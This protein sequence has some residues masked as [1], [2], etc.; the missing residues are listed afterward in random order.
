VG[1]GA[2]QVPETH[3]FPLQQSASVVQL[4]FGGG[5]QAAAQTPPTQDWLQQSLLAVQA[6]PLPT[7]HLPL[8]HG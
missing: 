6:A 7:Q 1:Q 8:T 2:A 3:T 4:P 5:M